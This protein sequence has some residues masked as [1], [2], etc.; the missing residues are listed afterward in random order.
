MRWSIAGVN[1]VWLRAAQRAG[2]TRSLGLSVRAVP[3]GIRLTEEKSPS[4]TNMGG[5]HPVWCGWDREAGLP[6]QI[7]FFLKLGLSSSLLQTSEL[8]GLG[9]SDSVI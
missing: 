6:L 8:L 5:H 1:S 2:E 9:P 4:L 3:E 7:L